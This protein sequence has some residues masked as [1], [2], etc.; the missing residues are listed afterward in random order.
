M[1]GLTPHGLPYPLPTEPVAEGAAA[2]RSLAE[3]VD[4][5]EAWHE[6]GGP[7]EPGFAWYW[8][9]H[10]PPKSTAAFMRD[11]AGF[12]HIKGTVKN[13]NNG[14]AVFVLPTDYRPAKNE[15]FVSVAWDGTAERLARID[16]QA[17]DGYVLMTVI[18]LSGSTVFEA[19]L[20]GITFRA[21][22]LGATSRPGE[23]AEE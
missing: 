22:P 11:R 7:G 19:G 2:I 10:G 1:P 5:P 9:N 3:A 16:V 6:V 13:G 8:E 18:A 4:H 20:G 17:A 23:E 15:R 14:Q 12:V 21:E